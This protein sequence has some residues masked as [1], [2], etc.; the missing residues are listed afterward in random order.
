MTFLCILADEHARKLSK[1]FE[2]RCD[3]DAECSAGDTTWSQV[4]RWTMAAQAQEREDSL[5]R[6]DCREPSSDLACFE[7]VPPV[8]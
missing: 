7:L 1:L 4:R 8:P 6:S 2:A 5:M 3:Q